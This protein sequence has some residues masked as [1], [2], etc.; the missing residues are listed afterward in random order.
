MKS[1]T[2]SMRSTSTKP[3]AHA[4]GTPAKHVGLGLCSNCKKPMRMNAYWDRD[5][6]SYMCERC[7]DY[8]K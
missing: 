5:T 3:K 7:T 2:L 8:L 4:P 1:T 6:K